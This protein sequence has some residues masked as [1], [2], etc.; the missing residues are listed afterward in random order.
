MLFM[1]SVE[2]DIWIPSE[3][4]PKMNTFATV[5]SL[6]VVLFLVRSGQARVQDILN[7]ITCFT[8]TLSIADS[9]GNE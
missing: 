7:Y 3:Y 5:H 9:R 4:Y 6:I 1:I 8:V 2:V